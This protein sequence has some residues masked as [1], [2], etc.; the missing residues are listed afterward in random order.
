MVRNHIVPKLIIE[1]F[2]RPINLFNTESE[3]LYKDRNPKKTFWEEGAYDDEVEKQLCQELENPFATVIDKKIINKDKIVLTR[4]ELMLVKRFLLIQSVRTRGPNKFYDILFDFKEAVDNSILMHGPSL[5][6]SI[7]TL[8]SITEKSDDKF[9]LYMQAIKMFSECIV[10]EEMMWHE[11]ATKET[12]FWAKTFQD[13]YLVFWDSDEKQDFILT[14]NGMTTEYDLC[15]MLIEG[16][17]FLSKSSYLLA[18]FTKYDKDLWKKRYYADIFLKNQTMN[19]NFNVFNLTANRCV[20]VV[21][22]FF[23]PYSNKSVMI[24]VPGEE[25]DADVPDIWPTYMEKDAFRVP[26]NK[27]IMGHIELLDHDEY[28]YTPYSL[29]LIETVYVNTLALR[30]SPRFIG[31]RDVNR[32]ID[33]IYCMATWNAMNKEDVIKDDVIDDNAF[34]KHFDEDVY[35]KMMNR[36]YG[37]SIITAY[38]HPL[39]FW[40]ICKDK[41]WRDIEGNRYLLE[42]FLSQEEMVRTHDHFDVMG[43]PDEKI[44][45][46]KNCLKKLN[47]RE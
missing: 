32:I 44:E 26:E 8:P 3:R 35:V 7:T 22:P 4:N 13:S 5:D 39:L 17:S 12:Y 36:E 29:S 42:Y 37:G 14:D 18:Q 11:Y 33:S 27:H 43:T 31:F 10:A 25:I 41:A 40:D 16:S 45:Y 30:W 19:E 23:R 15:S 1:R 9:T 2:A 6:S 46:L 38:I 28:I 24:M 21:N 34:K 47:N 20:A